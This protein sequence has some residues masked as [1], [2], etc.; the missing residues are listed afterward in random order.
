[1]FLAEL[2]ANHNGILEAS[3]VSD[4]RREF[5]DRVIRRAGLEPQY[6]VQL[7]TVRDG[8]A[9]HYHAAMIAATSGS[10]TSAPTAGPS[11][12]PSS[13]GSGGGAAVKTQEPAAPKVPGFGKSTPLPPVPDFSATPP[14]KPTGT[15]LASASG[16]TSG[17]KS[18]T[19]SHGGEEARYRAYAE[20]LLRQYDKNKNGA[21]DRDEWGQL[22]GDPATIDRNKDGAITTDELTIWV[23][24][25]SRRATGSWGS[26]T[27]SG[28]GG[29]RGSSAARSGETKKPYRMRTPTERLPPGL[30]DWFPR[31]DT[32]CDGQV[33][34]AEFAQQWNEAKVAEF[35]KYDLNGDGI[36]TPAECLQ[37]EKKLKK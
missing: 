5:V 19:T 23:T 8:L 31:K 2:D 14:T 30:P 9:K 24:E 13:G 37:V 4:R 28:G 20:S 10:S 22:Q 17:G 3:E 11:N 36:I 12:Q 6:P 18:G 29:A 34:M 21:L 32:D 25:Y 16:S 35:R 7:T 33:S 26:S 15:Q 1:L 27:T